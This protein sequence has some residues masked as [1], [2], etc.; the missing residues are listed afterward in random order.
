MIDMKPRI[1]VGE[2]TEAEGPRLT[3]V[4]AIGGD[5]NPWRPSFGLDWVDLATLPV[6][7]FGDQEVTAR[8]EAD[9][10]RFDSINQNAVPTLNPSRF[11]AIPWLL[12]A[13][14]IVFLAVGFVAK[15]T[16]RNVA[17][18]VGALVWF[19]ILFC[20]ESA[21]S[22]NPLRRLVGARDATEDAPTHD[23]VSGTADMSNTVSTAAWS[24]RPFSR[25]VS[26]YSQLTSIT[27]SSQ[28]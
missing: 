21:D 4:R 6:V 18:F 28:R 27:P 14:F 10:A 12:L 1:A 9:P 5:S 13:A 2:T 25:Q 15:P 8:D 17:V 3:A 22:S 16:E 20:S 24:L 23:A 7:R 26:T 19:Y 11:H